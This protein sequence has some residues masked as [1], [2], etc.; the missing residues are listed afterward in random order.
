MNRRGQPRPTL[1]RIAAAIAAVALCAA[2]LPADDEARLEFVTPKHLQTVLGESRIELA[3][4]LP[5]SLRAEKV[6]IR[7]DG[8]LLATL[9]RPPWSAPWDA[10][11]SE[12]A[13]TLDAILSLSD[14]TEVHA[15][16]RTSPLRVTHFEEVA[17]VN[18]Y[19][20]VRSPSGDYV[21]DLTQ[22]DFSIS[23]NERPQRIQRFTT[24]RKPLS[25]AIVLDNSLT[26]EGKKLEHA[27]EAALKF[28]DVLGEGDDAMV[29]TFSDEVVVKQELTGVRDELE[30]AILSAEAEGGTAL[31]DAVW[32]TSRRLERLDG[33]RVL[34]LLS[35][36]RDEASS[37]LEPGSLHTLNEALDRALRDEVIIFSIGIGKSLDSQPDFYGRTNLK[38]ILEE[39]AK[40]T[41]GRALF[42][43][44]STRLKKAFEEVADDLRHMYALAYVSDD[45]HH[46]GTW[47]E[48]TLRTAR[49]PRLVVYTRKGYFA[50]T[51]DTSGSY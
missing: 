4:S 15:S 25:V 1:G 44:S 49:D 21:T 6:E 5:A 48:I 20:V 10:G 22:E 11:S 36:G 18:L 8:E 47:R 26:M 29:V 50:P 37:G 9:D 30:R 31:Y 46:D 35:D 23:E 41:G 51:E 34:V 38:A 12:R 42:A 24:E 17:L 32:K 45:T 2:P 16:I 39:L 27:K 33:R 3:V 19:A 40:K 28:L 13:H 7:V 14:G 43:S